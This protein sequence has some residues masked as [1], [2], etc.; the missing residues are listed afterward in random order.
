[1]TEL[2][3]VESDKKETYKLGDQFVQC[4]VLGFQKCFQEGTD[5][6]EIVKSWDVAVENG[7]VVVK[8]FVGVR[9]PAGV[10]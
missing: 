1:M 3:V 5:L 4:L 9:A 2:N 6:G 8:S 7:E 10:Q